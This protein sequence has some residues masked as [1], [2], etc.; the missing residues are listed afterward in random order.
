MASSSPRPGSQPSTLTTI[1]TAGLPGPGGQEHIRND[2]VPYSLTS[3]GPGHPRHR[4]SLQDPSSGHF[5]LSPAP[6]CILQADFSDV[7]L[8]TADGGRLP[9]HRVILAA[10]SSYFSRM[11]FGQLREAGQQ[12][13]ILG[14][15]QQPFSLLLDHLYTGR[16]YFGGQCPKNPK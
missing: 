11:L 4:R 13:V 7:T 6:S 8:V 5:Q 3:P 9:A 15:R 12:E 1:Q 10:M 16:Q 14:V 2:D